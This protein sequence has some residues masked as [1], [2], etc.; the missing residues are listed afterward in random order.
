[1]KLSIREYMESRN[2]SRRTI[3][4]RIEN[5]QL[6]TIKEKNKTYI[7]K[8]NLN[9]SVKKIALQSFPIDFSELVKLKDLQENFLLLQCSYDILKEFDYN[10]LRERLSSIEKSLV[11][12]VIDANKSNEKINNKTDKFTE[13]IINKLGEIQRKNDKFLENFL[14]INEQNQTFFK[15]SIENIEN[16]FRI[17]EEKLEHLNSLEEKFNELIKN[18]DSKKSFG[19]FKK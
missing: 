16:K 5:G 6:E 1:M 10:F 13:E 14:L 8:E 11:N 9:R 7:I 19:L 12:F 17:I 3:Y 4:N 15:E 18:A 2:V